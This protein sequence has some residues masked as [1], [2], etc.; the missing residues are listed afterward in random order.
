MMEKC[1]SQSNNILL[2]TKWTHI[3]NPLT[4]E[5]MNLF[6]SLYEDIITMKDNNIT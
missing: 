4:R 6:S 1:I 5:L 3:L 2:H